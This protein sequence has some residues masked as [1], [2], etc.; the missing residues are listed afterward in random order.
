[1]RES[2]YYYYYYYCYINQPKQQ[3]C[4]PRSGPHLAHVDSTRPKRG[5]GQIW[6]DAMLLFGK[7]HNKSTPEF[8]GLVHYFT[9]KA[10]LCNSFSLFLAKNT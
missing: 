7:S 4:R 9:L 6:I 3:Q 1:M 10:T 5:V 8:K 2:F